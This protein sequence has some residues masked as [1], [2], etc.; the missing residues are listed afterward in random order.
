VIHRSK[1]LSLRRMAVSAPVILA[2]MAI[3]CRSS[4]PG[5]VLTPENPIRAALGRAD[6]AKALQLAQAGTNA[7]AKFYL[8]RIYAQGW[9]VKENATQAVQYYKEAADAG[10]VRAKVFLAG[11]YQQ[12]RGV[13]RDL[14]VTRQ[15]LQE[16]SDQGDV[17]A[18]Y[19][20][21]MFFNDP[22]RKTTPAE[23]AQ[24]KQILMAAADA[25]D[26]MA[27]YIVGMGLWEE[28][29]HNPDDKKLAIKYLSGSANSNTAFPGG[30]AATALLDKGTYLG[31]PPQEAKP[32]LFRF[33]EA[34]DAALALQYV[35]ICI[36][37]TANPLCDPVQV[38][39][40]N[41]GTDATTVVGRS[42]AYL[43]SLTDAQKQEG[44]R[45]AAEWEKRP[46]KP[47]PAVPP[48]YYIPPI[49]G[50]GSS[51]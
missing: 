7:E 28:S 11:A 32:I 15:L 44:Q 26:P 43:S 29:A 19:V 9:G 14:K 39:K 16:A 10:Y 38:I 47:M 33:I 49:F 5:S 50:P 41:G 35:D 22:K 42:R 25:G 13:K 3:A 48:D 30:L 31:T 12:G 17:Q 6:Y 34:G 18:K 40:Y 2:A 45:L 8:G 21:P 23:D 1:H 46:V 4:N 20:I 51:R 36:H 37:E 24:S 27:G